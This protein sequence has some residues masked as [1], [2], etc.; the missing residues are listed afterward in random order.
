MVESVAKTDQNKTFVE[1]MGDMK[2]LFDATPIHQKGNGAVFWIA[3]DLL[4]TLNSPERLCGLQ[5]YTH[6]LMKPGTAFIFPKTAF[7]C[8]NELLQ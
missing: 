6:K 2:K 3:S 7:E 4:L 5:V 1:T 8:S